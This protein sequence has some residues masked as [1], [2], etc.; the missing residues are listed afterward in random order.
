MPQSFFE[1]TAF[2][3]NDTF[4][5]MKSM[6]HLDLTKD[7]QNIKSPSLIICGEKDYPNI[8]S[9]LYL[10]AKI[11]RSKLKIIKAAGHVLNEEKPRLLAQTMLDFYQKNDQIDW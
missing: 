1:K 3:K 11:E 2:D 8:K 7:I 10:S 9:S 4:A 6:K 5:L